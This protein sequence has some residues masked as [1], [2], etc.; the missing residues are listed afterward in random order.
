MD[1]FALACFGFLGDFYGR[2]GV[3]VVYYIGSDWVGGDGLWLVE[4]V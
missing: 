3:A 4:Q 2:E 1:L